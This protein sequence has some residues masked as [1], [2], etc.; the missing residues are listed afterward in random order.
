MSCSLVQFCRVQELRAVR[1]F[2]F[3]E[4]RG[5]PAGGESEGAG[6]DKELSWDDSDW[7]SWDKDNSKDDGKTAE[8]CVH[9]SAPWLHDCTVS[10]SPC[11]DLLVIAHEHKAVFLSAKWWTDEAGHDEMTLTVSWS[12]TLNAE[13]GECVNSVICI[14][15]AS[16][17][18]SSTGRPDWTCV[19]VG[20]TSGYVRFY[21]ESG[22]LL[23]A[24]LLNEDPVLRLKCRTYEIPRHPGVT[25]QHEELSILYPTALVTI[26]GFSLFQS[27]RACRNQV[28][29][30]AAAG[31][32]TVQPPPL[33]YK[34]W[35]LQDMDTIVD[36]SSVGI[37][38]LCVFDQMKNA[39]ILGGFNA[40]VKGSPPAMCQYITVGGGP[41]TGFF[42]AIE[43]SSQPLLSHV[44]LAVASK[45]TSALFSAASGWLGWKNKNE[46]EPTQKQK[47]KVEPATPLAVRFGLPDSRR[48]GESICLSPCNTLAGVTDDFG[49]VTLLDVGRGIAI[50][51]WKGY[52]DAQLGWVQVSEGQEERERTTS[53]TLP[54]RHA[55]FLVI[56]APRRGILE[57]WGTQQGPRVGAFTVG[58]HCRLLYPGYRLMGVNSITSQGWQLHTQQVCLLDP[59]TGSLRTV[60]V[61]FHLALSDKKSE[62]AKDM[63][64]LK[65]L[66]TLLR[67]REVEP[68][69]LESEAQ[70]VLLEIKHPA[71][72]KQALESLLS[73]KRVPVSCLTNITCSLLDSLK[74]QDP[75]TVDETLLQLCSSQLKLLQL[76]TNIL[77]LQTAK[78]SSVDTD[79]STV[80]CDE[81]DEELDRIDPILRRYAELLSRPS[82]SFSQ[83]AEGPFPA[84]IFLSQLKAEGNTLRV[85]RGQDS[86]WTQLGSFL[87]WDCLCGQSSHQKLC[88]MLQDAGISPQDLLSLLLNVWLQRER[89]MLKNPDAVRH[90]HS[91]LTALSNM[92]GAVDE[93]WDPQCVSPWWQQVR[94]ACVQTESS[95]AA[96]LV[97]LV[98]HRTAKNSITSL[99]EKK[100]KS[101][102]EAV[103]LELEQWVVC[104]RQLEDVLA[105]QTLL[106]LPGPRGTPGGAATRCSVKALLESGRGGVAD[107]V[108]KWVFRQDLSP[109]LLK[110]ILQTRGEVESVPVS[111]EDGD[112]Q[113]AAEL[114]V[115]VCQRF[116]NS[117][118][119][120]LLFAHCCWEFVVQ[121]NK[122][123]E[124]GR[125]LSWSV[126]HLKLI[127]NPHIQL[128]IAL[129]MWSTFIVKRFSAAAFL[130]EKVGK[131]PKDRLCRRDVG[132]GDNAMTSFL[133]SC[134]QLL[135]TLMEA[136]ASIE[137]VSPPELS[138][139]EVWVGADGPASIAE[140]ALEQRTVHYPLVQHHC[141][142]ASLLHATMTFGVRVKPLSLF[143]SKGKNA[144]FRDLTTIQ[145]LPSGDMDAN[146]ISLRQEFL[147]KVLSGWVN[148]Q[149]ERTSEPSCPRQDPH[150]VSWA[151]LCLDL[152]P[153]LQ[154]NP[155][156]LRRHLVCEFYSH[157]LDLRAEEVML[158]VEDKDVLGSQLLVLTGQRLS[159]SLL[160][161]QTRPGMELLAR[162]PPMLCTWLKA[163]DPSELSCSSVP[164]SLISRMVSRV[165][166]MLP[167]NH[168][169]YSLALHLLE[170]VDALATEA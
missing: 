111:S 58:K 17:K 6:A 165:I 117:L 124:E 170:A 10:L 25:E 5:G 2:L 106:C 48:H 15:L 64:L 157:G 101:E 65:R 126:E 32:D 53:P 42:Y 125:Y 30:A 44:A 66:N 107:S 147:L 146:L 67:S 108:A 45:L 76:Y 46:E 100:F 144:F 28:A 141:L 85:A 90:L 18:R 60:N 86:D 68:D 40:A 55:Q 75:E 22:V 142:L 12:G 127:A 123:P 31:S 83:D 9:Q 121:W 73:S 38:S 93:S 159:Y 105:L 59:S 119:P 115:S 132:M 160:H 13:E 96:L 8:E 155:D 33:A 158:E 57:V 3:P 95:G 7:G 62:R 80:A 99:A 169:Q 153:L 136:D 122:D 140:L 161:T 91:L 109:A 74:K 72:K 163:M 34:K 61:P 156:L 4:Q 148:T 135:Q 167:D 52:R 43:G 143:D 47:P 11:S 149:A 71:I 137:E 19:V 24:Q 166:E 56:Y 103:S 37:M 16:Q 116:P 51:M 131:A 27:L 98:A 69:V 70:C 97:A 89:Q 41:F 88:E 113:R 94:T 114:L 92:S 139:E 77:S 110:D 162:L 138:V 21:T 129:M 134:T 14:P 26:D 128:G 164:L 1:E 63:H 154:V 78:L 145:L 29:R 102:W 150:E 130:M 151:S 50:R 82:V 168:A 49:R 79:A 23:L 20:F 54:R 35:G 118:S 36:H 104:L 39:S 133:G 112:F 152:A 81:T 84:R 87:F 120:D